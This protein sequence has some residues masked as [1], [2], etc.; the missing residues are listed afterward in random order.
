MRGMATLLLAAAWRADRRAGDPP[1]PDRLDD[2]V[3][4]RVAAVPLD[5][6]T[7]APLGYRRDGDA[8]LLWS[9]GPNGVDDGG[10]DGRDRVVR[11][12]WRPRG[13]GP[14]PAP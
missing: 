14:T 4:A 10:D 12:P 6:F 9:V 3:P 5:P 7:D 1:F 13:G 8:C 11:M 2:L